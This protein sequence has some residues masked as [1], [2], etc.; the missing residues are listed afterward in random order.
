MMPFIHPASGNPC[1]NGHNEKF[2]LA[3]G[4][5]LHRNPYFSVTLYE[6]QPFRRPGRHE[7]KIIARLEKFFLT[8]P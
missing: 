8:N 2:C 4:V 7:G 5:F 6:N 1:R 3:Y